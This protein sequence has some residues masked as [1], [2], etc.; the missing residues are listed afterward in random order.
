MWWLLPQSP[1]FAVPSEEKGHGSISFKTYMRYFRLGASYVA[2]C[3]VLLVMVVGEVRASYGIKSPMPI[4]AKTF[5]WQK[6]DLMQSRPYLA[7]NSLN[8]MKMNQIS[9]I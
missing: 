3:V 4:L 6:G 1:A 5:F 2:I 9:V 8:L 7:F